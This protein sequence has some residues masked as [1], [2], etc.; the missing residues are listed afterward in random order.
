MLPARFIHPGCSCL[1]FR[2]GL[3]QQ[4]NPKAEK[5]KRKMPAL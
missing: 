2:D 4:P 1:V 3:I 5:I